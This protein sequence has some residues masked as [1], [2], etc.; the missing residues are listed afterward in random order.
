[1]GGHRTYADCKRPVAKLEQLSYYKELIAKAE[2]LQRENKK[3]SEI[4]EL[5]NQ[6][7]WKPPKTRENFNEG[8]V[9]VL[10]GRAGVKYKK[11]VRSVQAVRLKDEWTLREL[12]HKTEIPEP[13]LYSWMKKNILRARR[14]MDTS[15]G[16]VWLITANEQEVKRLR[17]LK[18][19]P[20]EWVYHSRVKRME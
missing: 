10:L 8:V 19:Q 6:E 4:A 2:S 13:I 11:R 14:A 9:R 16:G 1:M 12:S 18:N 15:H 5:L 17:S 20:K 7:G 3:F